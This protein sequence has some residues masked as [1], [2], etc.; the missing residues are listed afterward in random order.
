VNIGNILAQIQLPVGPRH[1]PI[2][3]LTGWFHSSMTQAGSDLVPT[4]IIMGAL[5][6]MFKGW[7]GMFAGALLGCVVAI[8][9]ANADNIR[10]WASTISL[11]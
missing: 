3:G 4:L 7:M 1:D 10:N 2:T 5:I 6:G 8:F 11:G 9:V